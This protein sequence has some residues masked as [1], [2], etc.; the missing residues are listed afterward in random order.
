MF[1]YR[2]S[3]AKAPLLLV[4]A[5]LNE[6]FHLL[7]TL[8]DVVRGAQDSASPS[9][10][11]L[12]AEALRAPPRLL[13]WA[14]ALALLEHAAHLSERVRLSLGEEE[15]LREK[16]LVLLLSL[17]EFSVV[18]DWILRRDAA[19][20]TPAAFEEVLR[21]LVAL[22]TEAVL[23]R[24]TQ[25][26]EALSLLVAVTETWSKMGKV[27]KLPALTRSALDAVSDAALEALS[28][29]MLNTALDPTGT[30]DISL[31]DQSSTLGRR[32]LCPFELR[33]LSTALDD[34]KHISFQSA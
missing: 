3:I 29:R 27:V 32:G 2:R 26:C 1:L 24:R 9:R 7:R 12:A 5:T 33:R 15:V 4:D 23:R 18:F 30:Q 34:F 14:L 17:G 10:A 16:E 11:A 22:Q 21:K 28:G 13:P 8:G 20:E 31:G 6:L 19:K 25:V